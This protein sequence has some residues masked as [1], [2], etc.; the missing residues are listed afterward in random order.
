[1]PNSSPGLVAAVLCDQAIQEGQTA[2]WSLIGCFTAINCIVPV[3]HP[4]HILHPHLA[5]YFCV[6]NSAGKYPLEVRC[7]HYAGAAPTEIQ[8]VEGEIDCGPSKLLH[9]EL[10][11]NFTNVVFP[12][13]GRYAFQLHMGGA[14]IGE[15]HFDV[16]RH[17]VPLQPPPQAQ[18]G[19]Q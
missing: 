5:I 6:S 13:A 17:E 7:I 11:L 1:V 15:K 19:Q 3:G 18:G 16:N 10:A 2:K 8:K 4:P 9:T 14:F 12:A